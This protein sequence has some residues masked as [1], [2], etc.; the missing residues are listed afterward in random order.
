MRVTITGASGLIGSR[1]LRALR[2]RGDEVTVLSR[3][4]ERT[5]GA[6]GVE[7]HRWDPMASAAPAGDDFLAR[8]CI[9]W[10]READ[11][12]SALLMRVVRLR[13]GVVLD[14]HGGAL[15]KML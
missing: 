1:L 2:E 15:A 14:A 6:L 13:T 9:A 5:A 4:P 12:A 11:P 3:S 10:E 7:A 8:V